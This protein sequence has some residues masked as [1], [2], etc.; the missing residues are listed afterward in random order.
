MAKKKITMQQ[1]KDF[2][3]KVP[4]Y[5]KNNWSKNQN[6]EYDVSLKEATGMCFAD[7]GVSTIVKIVSYVSFVSTSA[8]VGLVFGMSI[9]QIY[10]L[11]CI[12]TIV[13]LFYIGIN[14]TI[15]DS[16]GNL[17]KK[18]L[19]GLHISSILVLVVVI[20]LCFVDSSRFDYIVTDIFIH[21]AIIFGAKIFMTYLSLMVYKLFGKKHGKYKPWILFMGLPTV[22][23][24]TALTFLPYEDLRPNVLLIFVN[25]LSC[26]LGSCTSGY[27]CNNMNL[28]STNIESMQNLITTNPQER[29]ILH[30]I[31][32]ILAGLLASLLTMFLPLIA[33]LSGYEENSIGIYRIIVPAFGIVGT[34]FTLFSMWC[35][36]KVIPSDNNADKPIVTKTAMKNVFKNKYLWIIKIGTTFQALSALDLPILTYVLL[37]DTRMQWLAVILAALTALPST[38]GNLVTPFITKRMS[39]HTAYMMLMGLK[40]L[41]TMTC[42]LAVFVDNAVIKLAIIVICLGASS[43]VNSSARVIARSFMGD[44]LDYHQWRFHERAEG[45]TAYFTYLTTPLTLALGYV[46]PFLFALVGLVDDRDVLYDDEVRGGILLMLIILYSVETVL[47]CLPYIFYDLTLDKQKQIRSDLKERALQATADSDEI[48][49]TDS[50]LTTVG[51]AE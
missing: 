41:V 36:E 17:S 28:S 27:C 31:F 30:S 19:K 29:V 42:C 16:L 24:A 43:F 8:V 50:N 22:V 34:A 20:G 23:F 12:A 37:Y 9:Q 44:A 51:G 14:A 33:T 46:T 13:N 38:P 45:A 25:L 39:K 47:T 1:V 11:T 7:M 2:V 3:K 49:A 26:L 5:V 35:S 10:V 40:T 48:T 4:P 15:V 21:I 18:T 6:P 32:P